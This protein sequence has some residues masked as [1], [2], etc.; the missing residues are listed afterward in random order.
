MATPNIYW[1]AL[2]DSTDLVSEVIKRI[3]TYRDGLRNS[4]RSSKMVRSWRTLYGYGPDGNKTTSQITLGGESG[5]IAILPTNQYAALVQQVVTLATS[6]RPSYKAVAVNTDYRSLAEASFAEQLMDVVDRDLSLSEREKESLF[7]AVALSEG[8]GVLSWDPSTGE[9]IGADPDTGRTIREGGIDVLA[10]TPFDVAYDFSAMDMDKL[11]W[12]CFKRRVSRWDLAETYPEKRHEIL[13]SD[14]RVGSIAFEWLD[15]DQLRKDDTKDYVD[16]WEL[17]HLPTASCP[18]GRLVR[19]VDADTVLFDTTATDEEGQVLDR[20][21][22]YDSL[23]FESVAP[24]RMAGTPHAHTPFFDL[25]G[26]QEAA[27]MVTTAMTSAINAG[28]M[29][30]LYIQRGANIDV[31]QLTSGLN[32]IEGDGPPPVAIDGV[33]ISPEL[34]KFLE[35]VIQF[36]RNRVAINDVVAGETPKNM[37][38]QGMALQYAQA[39]QFNQSLQTSYNRFVERMRTGVVK[40]LKRFANTQ[41]VAIITGKSKTWARKEFSKKDLMNVDRIMLEPVNPFSKTVAGRM[42]IAE[43]LLEMGR[44]SVDQYLTFLDTGQFRQT[45]EAEEANILRI[46]R[47][48]EMLS[49][50]VGLP[51]VNPQ[52]GDFVDDG[53]QHVRPLITD[54]HWLDIPEYLSVLHSPE[55]RD[56]PESVKAVLNA[57]HYKLDLWRQLDPALLAAMKGP[58]PPPLFAPGG[59][60]P[61]AAN[62]AQPPPPAT[63]PDRQ[64]KPPLE[65]AMGL[66]DSMPGGAP[67]PAAPDLPQ[68]PNG[69]MPPVNQAT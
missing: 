5:E 3:N 52:T 46:Q 60:A 26:L 19:F 34:P 14:G 13:N 68:T 51:P 6:S 30:N 22:P 58:P 28:G 43:R 64:R 27:D 54:T 1:A 56:N 39:V 33:K 55:A 44:I 45:Y 59:V 29:M 50:G 21:Y 35:L 67:M 31:R 32:L 12:C 63:K 16:V 65:G 49:E 38:A 40:L 47:D 4:D 20:G 7:Y 15:G 36:M 62:Q 8:F 42:Q 10:L 69:A 57:V 41:R 17:R 2:T 48:K 24:M 18:N 25:I 9:T 53:R 61:E 37:P 11:T 66:S 23:H